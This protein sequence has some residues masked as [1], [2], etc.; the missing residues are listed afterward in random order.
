MIQRASDI[1]VNISVLDHVHDRHNHNADAA[2]HIGP[3]LFFHV[4]Y[5]NHYRVN[6]CLSQLNIDRDNW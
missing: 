2:V 3:G 5:S 1:V 6:I 4:F